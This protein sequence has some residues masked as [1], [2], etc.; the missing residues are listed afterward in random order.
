MS[1]ASADMRSDISRQWIKAYVLG[2]F[3]YIAATST[4]DLI[5]RLLGIEPGYA[6]YTALA[7]V[8]LIC[9][10]GQS[11]GLL[12]IGYL[13]AVALRQRIPELPTRSWLVLYGIFGIVLGLL[14][15][16]EW[17]EETRD[18][19]RM[20]FD[21]LTILAVGLVGLSVL[22]ALV[23]AAA[24]ALQAFVLRNVA[25]GLKTWIAYSAVAGVTIVLMV[26]IVVYGPV[27]GFTND[28]L[29]VVASFCATV[30]GAFIMLPA[31]NQL[32]PR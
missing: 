9:V 15:A 13:T 1:D 10:A 17:L 24:G 11:F 21:N 12:V 16:T 3:A 22:G 18:L 27:S 25:Q 4:G 29:G 8:C 2:G 30:G 14:A 5:I 20:G 32:R 28:I 6:T 31:V 23:G 7:V 19:D 26:P